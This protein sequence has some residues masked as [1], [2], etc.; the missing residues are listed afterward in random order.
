[1][2]RIAQFMLWLTTPPE[3][4]RLDLEVRGSVLHARRY[5]SPRGRLI[6]GIPGLGASSRS[7]GYLGPHV[8]RGAQQLVALDLRGRGES[9]RTPPGTY[10][11]RRHAADVID[12][13]ALLQRPPFDLVGHSMGAFVAMQVVA[14][15]PHRVR[16]L[17]LIDA[18]GAPD[19]L[20]LMTV[21]SGEPWLSS[22]ARS[23]QD[24]V[25]RVR[26]AGLV[27]PWSDHWDDYFRAELI[28]VDGRL[29]SRNDRWAVVEDTAHASGRNPRALWGALAVPVLLVRATRPVS[30]AGGFMIPDTERAAFVRAV[31]HAEVVEV[32]ANHL[33]LMTHHDCAAAIRRFLR[34]SDTELR[35]A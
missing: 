26:E 35:S 21:V 15:A 32:D 20:A 10:G 3:P 12:A 24:Y 23:S 7:F 18:A 4:M 34:V 22:M 33:G 11:W 29:R 19:A 25:D 28:S 9:S 31:P 17:V 30:R 1:M 8:G 14:L 2:E 6:I 13:A 27:E 16:R 5:G